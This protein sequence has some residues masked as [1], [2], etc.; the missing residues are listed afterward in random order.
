LARDELPHFIPSSALAS[1]L[2][3]EGPSLRK[4]VERIRKQTTRA[5]QDAYGTA[6]EPD[7]IIESRSWQG[8][9]LNPRTVNV[10]TRREVTAR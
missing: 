1:T 4:T 7:A 5:F 6:P 2:S 9:R 8:Y 3:I 10:S